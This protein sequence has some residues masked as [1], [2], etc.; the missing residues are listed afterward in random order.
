MEQG[1]HFWHMSF[2][3]NT[4][5]GLMFS[6]RFGHLTVPPSMTRFDAQAEIRKQV[7]STSPELASAVTISFDIQP[8]EL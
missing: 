7:I 6:E 5:G 3:S 4:P 2:V 1:T 8:N